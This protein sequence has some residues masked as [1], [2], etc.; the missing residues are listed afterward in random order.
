MG[1]LLQQLRKFLETENREMLDFMFTD[2][3]ETLIEKLLGKK[4][5]KSFDVIGVIG[6]GSLIC[7][8]NNNIYKSSPIVWLDSEGVP[9][10]V[11]CETEKEL[12]TLLCYSTDL[13]LTIVSDVDFDKNNPELGSKLQSTFNEKKLKSVIKEN[14]EYF[15]GYEKFLKWLDTE[16]GINPA[17]NP[18][19]IIFSANKKFSAFQNWLKEEK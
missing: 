16:L 12:L 14:K 4:F 18:A 8:W 9:N 2:K 6:T 15:F 13:I 7:F 10:C 5:I 11:I 3:N 1:I 19:E 17:Q